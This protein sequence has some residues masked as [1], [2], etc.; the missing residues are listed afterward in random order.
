[1]IIG[2]IIGGILI[3]ALIIFNEYIGR[4]DLGDYDNGVFMGIIITIVV[5][6]EVYFLYNINEE[7]TPSAIDVYRGNTELEITSV[8]GIPTDTIVVYKKK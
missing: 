5:A 8:N 3:C 7:P 6:S 4:N 2:A 1:M